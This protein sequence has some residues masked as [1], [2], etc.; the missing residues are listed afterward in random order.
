DQLQ[1]TIQAG[2]SYTVF[3]DRRP[4]VRLTFT[5]AAGAASTGGGGSVS[6]G[7][8]STPTT[9][10]TKTTEPAVDL[11][12]RAGTLSGSVST[13]GKL[14]LTLKGKNVSSLK[15]GKYRLSVIDETSKSGFS[16]Q[17]LGKSATNV[18]SVKL[19]GKHSVTLTLTAGQWYFYSPG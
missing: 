10:P 15:A 9:K 14:T 5:S 8:G 4:T 3:D 12:N 19:V 7:G 6:T 18:T 17:R 13:K 2:G 1:A 11:K 16:I